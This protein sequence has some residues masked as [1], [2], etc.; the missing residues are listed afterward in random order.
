MRKAVLLLGLGLSGTLWAGPFDVLRI[1][2]PYSDEDF[3]ALEE[4]PN[5]AAY[6]AKVQLSEL[7][8]R[9]I[10][11]NEQYSFVSCE[12]FQDVNLNLD[13]YYMTKVNLT[14]R[15]S[16]WRV[17]DSVNPP[18]PVVKGLIIARGDRVIAWW[19]SE[20]TFDKVLRSKKISDID[21][22]SFEVEGNAIFIE[23]R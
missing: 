7:N 21:T 4:N 15:L 5:A 16:D 23:R 8:K 17:K 14:V 1:P 18:K 9:T 13:H 10:Q 6:A 2:I 12:L 3:Y 22:E 20:E 19:V 11:L